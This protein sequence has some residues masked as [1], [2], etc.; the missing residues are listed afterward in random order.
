[1]TITHILADGSQK[2]DLTGHVV[3]TK[4]N[5]YDIL[6]RITRRLQNEKSYNTEKTPTDT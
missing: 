4:E 5:T 1:M 2:T 6:T 3:K